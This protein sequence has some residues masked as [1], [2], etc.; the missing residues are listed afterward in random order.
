MTPKRLTKSFLTLQNKQREQERTK[1]DREKKAHEKDLDQ[2]RTR[3]EDA[4]KVEGEVK[5]R[6]EEGTAKIHA[7][8]EHLDGSRSRLVCEYTAFHALLEHTKTA[9]NGATI[10]ALM[11]APSFINKHASSVVPV[12]AARLEM[13]EFIEQRL[14]PML[15]GWT[16][17]TTILQAKLLHAALLSCRWV[18]VPS[19]AWGMAYAEA[20]GPAARFVIVAVEPTWLTFADAWKSEAGTCWCEAVETPDVLHLLMFVDVDRALPQCWA[21][22]WLDIIAGYRPTLPSP[23]G[24]RWPDNLRVLACPAADDAVLPVPSGVLAHWAGVGAVKDIGRSADPPLVG[25]VPYAAWTGWIP[26]CNHDSPA[27]DPVAAELG[28]GRACG[29]GRLASL[30]AVLRRRGLRIG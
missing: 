28:R 20:I 13:R 26:K 27:I 24:R 21:R 30:K 1:F 19:P 11:S 4:R 3:I 25:H 17:G 5:M 15:A 22:P 14:S 16:S 18:V 9:G 2:C 12:G 10:S 23:A 8:A 7:A 6:I 29:L